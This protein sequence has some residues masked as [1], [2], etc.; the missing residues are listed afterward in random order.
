VRCLR[1][2]IKPQLLPAAKGQ[3]AVYCLVWKH[4][5]A[6]HPTILPALPAICLMF[7]ATVS[8]VAS[9][10]RCTGMTAASTADA[11]VGAAAVAK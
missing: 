4:S 1:S 9:W 11:A 6:P 3:T 5:V 2:N 8:N 7:P 10:S